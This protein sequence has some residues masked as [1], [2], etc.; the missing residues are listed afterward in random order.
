MITKYREFEN[1]FLVI[2]LKPQIRVNKDQNKS[3]EM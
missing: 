3:A 2:E 1:F